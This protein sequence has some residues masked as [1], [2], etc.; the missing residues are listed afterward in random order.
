LRGDLLGYLEFHIEQGPELENLDLPIGV[1]EAIAGQSRLDFHFHGKSGH[2]GTTPMRLRQDALAGA[3]EW[4]GSVERIAL[5]TPGLVAT[6]G[7]IETRPGAGNV[8][9][10]EA[11]AS[12][13]VRHARDEV[14]RRAVDQI[15]QAAED[16]ARKRSLTVNWESRLDQPAVMCDTN[17]TALL[18]RAVEKQ[19][20]VA[21]RMV[22]GAGHDAMALARKVP[23]TMLFLRS[24]GGISHHPDESVRREDVEAALGVGLAFLEE[25]GK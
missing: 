20:H 18:A 22:S 11:Q 7:R 13:D 6:V 4:I 14:R 9:A 8:I 15:S 10:G 3:A 12:L 17:L 24:P 16:S 5:A 23:V 2:A 21:H 19:G 25:L 1:V